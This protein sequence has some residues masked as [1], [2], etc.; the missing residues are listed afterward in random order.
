MC[1]R[2]RSTNDPTAAHGGRSAG[3]ARMNQALTIQGLHLT[4]T[5]R[6]HPDIAGAVDEK[7]EPINTEG[8]D[9]T[10]R[11]ARVVK[12]RAGGRESE[13]WGGMHMSYDR[14]LHVRLLCGG[15]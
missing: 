10:R 7:T 15:R 12:P 9:I 3:L 6:F 2:D 5:C 14:E 8:R 1:I 4:P 13:W 11:S